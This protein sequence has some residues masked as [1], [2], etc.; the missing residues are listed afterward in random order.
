MLSHQLNQLMPENLVSKEF[1]NHLCAL[2]VHRH[3]Y[4]LC[5]D[6][7]YQTDKIL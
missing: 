7:K 3:I 1:I 4:S 5:F 6:A 2:A